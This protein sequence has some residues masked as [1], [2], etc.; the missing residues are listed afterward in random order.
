MNI[1]AFF[2]PQSDELAARHTRRPPPP[3]RRP[4]P[5]RGRWVRREITIYGSAR[6]LEWRVYDLRRME[7]RYYPDLRVGTRLIQTPVG[8]Q[9][10]VKLEG[11]D[12][13]VRRAERVARGEHF[14]DIY[15]R[16]GRAGPRDIPTH[17][18]WALDPRRL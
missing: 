8:A 12:W 2:R 3:R 13:I 4:P 18:R 15:T 7:D 11:I 17:P 16:G 5:R 9:L 6:D 1:A 14:G 10:K